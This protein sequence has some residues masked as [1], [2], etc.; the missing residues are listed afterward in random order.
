MQSAN[1]TVHLRQLFCSLQFI[2]G[3]LINLHPEYWQAVNLHV[4][5]LHPDQGTLCCCLSSEIYGR[6]E[7]TPIFRSFHRTASSTTGG[8]ESLEYSNVLFLEY[9]SDHYSLCFGP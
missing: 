5:K 2:T 6:N 4:V 3:H 8:L 7:V 9:H 1:Y